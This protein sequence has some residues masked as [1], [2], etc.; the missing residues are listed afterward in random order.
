MSSTK[1]NK[2]NW[3]VRIAK[4]SSKVK[5]YNVFVV[6]SRPNAR[7]SPKDRKKKVV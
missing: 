4:R 3:N 5:K 2:L 1:L 6:P 7:P